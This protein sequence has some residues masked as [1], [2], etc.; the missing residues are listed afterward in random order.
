[1]YSRRNSGLLYHSF[2]EFGEA[3]GTWMP[4]V[5]CQLMNG[6]VGDTY[7]M[8]NTA[9]VI[10]SS[11]NEDGQYVY[12]PASGKMEFGEHANGRLI[13][14]IM[15]AENKV[16]EWNTIDLYCYGT[17]AVHVVN[18]KTVMVNEN[19][20][21]WD[22]EKVNPLSSGKIQLQSEGAEM[23]IRRVDIRDINEIPTD[24]LSVD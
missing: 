17:T 4:N 12:N 18:G 6:N 19:I 14:K 23:F 24:I 8:A 21:A 10:S 22:G 3:H 13:R 2:G 7:L 5:E 1:M 15:N 20:G 16:G 9:C 11:Q